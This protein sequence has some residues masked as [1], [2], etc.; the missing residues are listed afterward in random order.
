LRAKQLQAELAETLE[1]ENKGENFT[2]IEPP[3]VPSSAEKPNR[4]KLLAMGF[5]A[6]V[7]SGVGL[8]FLVEIFLGGVRGYSNI[9]RVVGKPPLVVI[10][11]IR[12]E[13]EKSRRRSLLYRSL[14]LLVLLGIA[15]IVLFHFFVMNLEVF[16]F[17]LLNKLSLL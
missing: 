7:G 17:K 15:A 14:F 3:Q 10:P 8:A 1:S 6:S 16:W 9:S 2:L 13:K 4:P 5:A 12:T 11:L